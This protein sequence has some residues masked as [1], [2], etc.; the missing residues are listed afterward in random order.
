M[1]F[2][3]DSPGLLDSWAA[4]PNSNPNALRAMQG[5]S[6]Y[7]FLWWSLVWPGREANSRPTVRE[8][9]T[10]QTETTRHGE[11]FY[12][13]WMTWI[14]YMILY[15]W[16]IS[17]RIYSICKNLWIKFRYGF[18]I[19]F[20]T[21]LWRG[22]VMWKCLTNWNWFIFTC[23]CNQH[24]CSLDSIHLNINVYIWQG[25]GILLMSWSKLLQF[26]VPNLNTNQILTKNRP[27]LYCIMLR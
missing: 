5:G 24:L 18:K 3:I 25:Y 20:E 26:L 8:V 7:H 19:T 22:V 16:I 4:L 14:W 17:R 23:T 21:S 9:D 27:I 11:V 1:H 12:I 13:K 6:L 2:P 15:I 10:L